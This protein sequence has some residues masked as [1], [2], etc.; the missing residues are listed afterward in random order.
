VYTLLYPIPALCTGGTEQQL[1]ELV[2]GLDKRRFRPI[3]ATL[4]SGGDLEPQFR[5]EPDVELVQLRNRGKGDLSPIWQLAR[6]LRSRRV[7]VVQP[8]LTPTTSFGLLA[9]LL[10]GTPV[11]ILT[12]RSGARTELNL[13]LRLQDALTRFATCVVANSEA[14]RDCLVRRGIPARKV[15]VITNGINRQ[16]LT[17]DRAL[18]CE[19]RTRLGVPNDGHVIGILA[20]LLPVKDHHTFL[21]AA[22]LVS[23]TFPETRFAIF[24]DGPMRIELNALAADLGLE[25]RVT[26]FGSQHGVADCLTACDVLVSTSLVEG[27]SNAI[28]EAMG[29]GVPVIATDIPGNREIV[30]RGQTGWCVPVRN[31]DVLAATIEWVFKH[32]TEVAERVAQAKE[33]VATRFGLDR[34]VSEHVA[35]YESLLA[36]RPHPALAQG[37]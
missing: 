25:E 31:P 23:H 32:P 9:G 13:H 19:Y 10:A 3:V 7:E 5:A 17:V 35:L 15:L 22:A 2:R 24:G 34:M 11:R 26:F 18:V 1:L 21:R 28:L 36:E 12:E 6:V 29:L 33:M 27:L 20:S 14:G 30:L 4:R 16:R 8:F 37:S